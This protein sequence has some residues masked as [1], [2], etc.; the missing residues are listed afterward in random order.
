LILVS[1]VADQA[2]ADGADGAADERAL[3]GAAV[4][5]VADNR[6]DRRAACA[7]DEGALGGV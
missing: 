1:L 3:G 5:V 6:A 4:G 7:A 2:A